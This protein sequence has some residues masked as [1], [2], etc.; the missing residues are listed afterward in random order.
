M[1]YLKKSKTILHSKLIVFFFLLSI[2][3]VTINIKQEPYS[4]YNENTKDISGIV[5]DIK[6]TD[7]GYKLE[8]K[9]KEK[10]IVYSDDF[11]GKLGNKVKI[12][13]D[14][15]KPN[16][17]TVFNLFNYQDY[18]K[19]QKIYWL[20]KNAD[21]K[22]IS[23]EEGVYNL[24][25]KIIDYINNYKSYKYLNAFILGNDDYIAENIYNSYHINGRSH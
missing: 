3:Y 21:V 20:I 5:T 24:K 6:Q 4:H 2:I 12:M 23:N 22:I 16:K 9:A 17:N 8:V 14:F 10:V 15:Q 19:S 13:G 11:N 25:N 7:Y 18:L 1:Q